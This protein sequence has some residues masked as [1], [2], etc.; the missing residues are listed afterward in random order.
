MAPNTVLAHQQKE[1]YTTILVNERTGNLEIAHRFSI[2]DAEHVLKQH[3]GI[4]ADI[5]SS[6]DTQERFAQ[7]VRLHFAIKASEIDNEMALLTVGH[8]VEGKYF[9]VYQE[10]KLPQK[11]D[12]LWVKMNAFQEVW[13]KQTN[14]VNFE[15][16]RNIRSARFKKDD[17]WLALELKK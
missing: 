15:K 6:S 7:Y 2:H 9:W 16:G 14:H 8:E 5:I 13:P 3:F 17:E 1:A 4:K 12:V 11:H 10:V